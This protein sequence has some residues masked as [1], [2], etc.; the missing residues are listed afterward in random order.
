MK[1]ICIFI[2]FL[3]I[4]I[5]K[6]NLKKAWVNNPCYLKG[7]F[8]S[9]KNI[10]GIGNLNECKII[11]NKHIQKDI[12]KKLSIVFNCKH[13]EILIEKYVFREIE[14]YLK[15]YK[16]ENS[17]LHTISDIIAH[18]FQMNFES[19]VLKFSN[20]SKYD[21]L[22]LK[23]VYFYEMI[24]STFTKNKFININEI[25]TFKVIFLERSSIFIFKITNGLKLLILI[26]LSLNVLYLFIFIGFRRNIINCLIQKIYKPISYNSVINQ[27]EL[28]LLML[29]PPVM[30]TCISIILKEHKNELKNSSINYNLYNTMFYS[31]LQKSK[32]KN[33]LLNEIN[34]CMKNILIS[35]LRCII[36]L[37]SFIFL[38]MDSTL[39]LYIFL[40]ITNFDYT[41]YSF[42]FLTI[43]ILCRLFI[44]SLLC[45]EAFSTLRYLS[46]SFSTYEEKDYL[47]IS[48]REN[49][50]NNI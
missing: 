23:L 48:S 35:K 34:F 3:K 50:E 33:V 41:Y 31:I 1:F 24:I 47:D 25:N 30:K 44:E 11:V 42:M 22:S 37:T 20:S 8:D 2:C 46:P 32:E 19:F 5:A 18:I 9:T 36:S 21:H 39:T 49:E 15:E 7:Y 12:Y 10:K 38:F 13:K 14:E 40:H 43:G 29:S 28:K 4:V 16:L 6:N 45:L 26:I 27:N 17:T